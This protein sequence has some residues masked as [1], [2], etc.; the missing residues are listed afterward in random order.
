MRVKGHDLARLEAD[1][2]C[3][4]RIPDMELFGNEIFFRPKF[5][6]GKKKNLLIRNEFLMNLTCIY[7]ATGQGVGRPVFEEDSFRLADRT[8]APW[9]RIGFG[10]GSDNE[11]PTLLRAYQNCAP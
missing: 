2:H 1:E 11:S 5:L 10:N 3:R 8:K 9:N 6:D 7:M 4:A